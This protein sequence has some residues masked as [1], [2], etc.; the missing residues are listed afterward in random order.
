M[1]YLIIFIP[2]SVSGKLTGTF[3]GFIT[4][5][6]PAPFGLLCAWR[7]V[8][9]LRQ[10]ALLPPPRQHHGRCAAAAASSAAGAS[11]EMGGLKMMTMRR[12]RQNLNGLASSLEFWQME[13]TRT[14][15]KYSLLEPLRS[16][17][18]QPKSE[19]TLFLQPNTQYTSKL[20]P[21][22]PKP[23]LKFWTPV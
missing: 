6:K 5:V 18:K 3:S 17:S 8:P 13:R 14:Y 9:I 4:R 19:L 16:S 21:G 15:G 7:E 10:Q 20:V 2:L 23:L 1:F 22:V 11:L 12:Q